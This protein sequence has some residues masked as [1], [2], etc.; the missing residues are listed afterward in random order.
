MATGWFLLISL[1]GIWLLLL[2]AERMRPALVFWARTDLWLLRVIVGQR[3]EVRGVG[4]IPEGPALVA[5]KH[6]AEWETMALLVMLPRSVVILKKE[7]LAIPVYGWYAR[8][9]GMI[10]IDR[11]AGAAALKHLATDAGKAMARDAQLVIFP[12]GTRRLV[13]D[14][15]DYKV[16]AIYLY[17]K[18]NVPMV[19]VALNSGLLWPRRR[20]V[21][22]PGTI[23]V[24]F[25][26]PIP[27]GLP[28]AEAKRRLVSA[29]ETETA[30][31]V[32]EGDPNRAYEPSV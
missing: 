26:P 28:R 13:G 22:Y 18:L 3:I 5:S 21:K 27:P 31:L 4:N 10:P 12:E 7:L 24:S 14:P 8:R 2:P 30:R 23:I 17:E 6:Q 1:T 19:P 32:A 15:P 20:F 25:L 16:G 11:S 9:S 29:V